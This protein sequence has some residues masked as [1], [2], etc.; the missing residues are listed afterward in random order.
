[1]TAS[2]RVDHFGFGFGIVP[3]ELSNEEEEVR[4]TAAVSVQGKIKALPSVFISEEGVPT[5][6]ERAAEYQAEKV[7]EWDV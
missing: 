4:V 6:R 7:A 3:D 5:L 1:M 2:Q